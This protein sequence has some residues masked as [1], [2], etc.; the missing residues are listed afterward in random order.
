M[1]KPVH[2][3]ELSC[4][5]CGGPHSFY[6]CQAINNMSQEDVYAYSS[7][8]EATKYHFKPQINPNNLSYRSNNVLTQPG[9][10]QPARPTFQN[11][12]NQQNQYNNQPNQQKQYNN[13][14]NQ[15][16]NRTNYQQYQ[17]Q[18]QPQNHNFQN[19]PNQNQYQNRNQYQ[20]PHQSFNQNQNR[21]QYQNPNSNY[22]ANQSQG[23]NQNQLQS[24]SVNPPPNQSTTD[25][26]LR[27][28]II[29]QDITNRNNQAS[30]QVLQNQV[31]QI[32]KALQE[33][34][35]GVLPSNTETNPR[36]ELKM[37]TTRSGSTL[38]G[39]PVPSSSLPSREQAPE[40]IIC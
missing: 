29:Q 16:Q 38:A 4:D 33:Q 21:N 6:E 1:Q 2:S 8:Q 25:D 9:F 15:Y 37:I 20:P 36:K 28:F 18:Y 40:T 35:S 23:F 34:P 22:Q 30:L 12:Q 19:Q 31:G 13:Q 11:N 17:N 32:A 26:L 39:P 10:T 3:I 27:Q 5:T 7:D 14:P 24:S